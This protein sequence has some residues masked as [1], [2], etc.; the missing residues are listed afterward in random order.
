MNRFTQLFLATS[1]QDTSQTLVS[2]A[3]LSVRTSFLNAV[4]FRRLCEDRPSQFVPATATHRPGR[5]LGAP[6]LAAGEEHATDIDHLRVA[7]AL[8]GPVASD[9]SASRFMGRIRDQPETFSYGFATMALSLCTRV[10]S[11]AGPRNPARLATPANALV[12]DIDA[13]RVHALFEKEDSVETH[14]GGYGSLPMIGMADYG[15]M[16]GAG[17][18][19]TVLLPPGPG[20]ER[21]EVP[22]RRPWSSFGSAAGRV[23]RR[24]RKPHW[25]EDPGPYR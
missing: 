22:Y 4:D 3:G 7:P 5:I 23:R 24:A 19:L 2:R 15:K 13:S 11:V 21:R 6:F 18:V 1:S 20:R 9:A 10:W 16:N 12:I 14:K 25:Q 17:E 8:F